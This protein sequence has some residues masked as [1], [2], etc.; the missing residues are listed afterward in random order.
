MLEED[1]SKQ[2]FLVILKYVGADQ[3]RFDELIKFVLGHDTEL[4]HRASW[5]L[6]YCVEQH[7]EF[8]KKHLKK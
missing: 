4:A 6:A 2:Q 8:S 5:P 3:K 1:Y 7:P